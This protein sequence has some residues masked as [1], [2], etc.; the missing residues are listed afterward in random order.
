LPDAPGRCG[1]PRIG[2]GRTAANA[3]A[4]PRPAAGSGSCA[5]ALRPRS[6]RFSRALNLLDG[7]GLIL[8]L[9]HR[10]HELVTDIYTYGS[11]S[12][13][14]YVPVSVLFQ[15]LEASGEC[16][17]PITWRPLAPARLQA[18]D[19]HLRC[20]RLL[21]EALL[22]ERPSRVRLQSQLSNPLF[23]LPVASCA[24]LRFS[25]RA[26]PSGIVQWS[27]MTIRAAIGFRPATACSPRRGRIRR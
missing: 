15:Y 1:R 26:A 11:P 25:G 17:L 4:V 2:R 21:V 14:T 22:M 3:T 19:D 13:H 24:H 9:E 5:S 20:V 23:P 12:L 10:V 18:A 16:A 7:T 8:D 6:S 27:G